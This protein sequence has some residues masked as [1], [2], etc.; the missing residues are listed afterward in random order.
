MS[1]S[2][3]SKTKKPINK[4]KP[5]KNKPIKNNKK[6]NLLFVVTFAIGVLLLVATYAWFSSSLN[7]KI[8]FIDMKVSTDTGLFIS[9][10]GVEFSDS[11]E[12][13]ESAILEQLNDTYPNHKNQWTNSGLWSVSTNGPKSSNDSFFDIYSGEIYRYREQAKRG[14]KF[15]VASRIDEIESSRWSKY[16][17]FDI[18]LK[19]VSGSPKSDNLFLTDDTIIEFENGVDEETRV[20][21][22]GIMNSIRFG[23]VR[24]G[25]TNLKASV[26]EIQ[27]L[28]CNNNCK[29]IIYEPNHTLH[30]E[31]SIALAKRIGVDLVDG[32]YVPTYGIIKEGKYLEHRRSYHNTGL[33]IDSEHFAIQ[34]TIKYDDLID[35]IF[36][37]PNGI[38]KLRIYIW[39]EGQDIDSLETSSAGSPIY[40][41]IDLEKDLSGYEGY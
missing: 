33:E 30:S 4:K 36:Q 28:Q 19:N 41:S 32:E 27:N 1:K 17:A 18:F 34:E 10:D 37:I 8:K 22:S 31:Y 26:N 38:T 29:S 21:M 14:Q 16:I 2:K 12:I 15:L 7:V 25:D 6:R 35:P 11:V 39:V 23:I 5:I 24:I 9:L 3:N 20:K 40:L 13:S